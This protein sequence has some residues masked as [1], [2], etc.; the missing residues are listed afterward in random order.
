MFAIC[1]H[2]RVIDGSGV[3]SAA[4]A[5]SAWRSHVVCGCNLIATV[6]GKCGLS[7]MQKLWSA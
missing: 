4:W 7:C 3:G 6:H 5:C 2:R 1:V